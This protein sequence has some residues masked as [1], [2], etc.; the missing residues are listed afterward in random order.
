MIA[1]V[2]SGD[3]AAMAARAVQL[4]SAFPM[5]LDLRIARAGTARVNDQLNPPLTY[6]CIDL[7]QAVEGGNKAP[8]IEI[9]NPGTPQQHIDVIRPVIKNDRVIGYLQL[10]NNIN[11]IKVWLLE[12]TS[13]TYVE[14]TQH[15]DASKPGILLGKVGNEDLKTGD[16]ASY[17]V[18]G[19][20]WQAKVWSKPSVSIL[21]IG[22]DV[23]FVF[24]VAVLL[25]GGVLYYL[26]KIVS[27]A[28]RTDVNSL[29][30]LTIETLRGTKQHQ[31][32]LQM[33]EFADAVPRIEE[34]RTTAPVERERDGDPN[35]I[36]YSAISQFNP[37]DSLINNA[38]NIAVEEIDAP[39]S[40][41]KIKLPVGKPQPKANFDANPSGLSP[42]PSSFIAKDIKPS[43]TD[44]MPMAAAAASNAVP[45]AEIFK[46]YDIRGIVGASLTISYAHQIGRALGSEAQTR[47][48]KRIA[49]GR[50]GRLSGP[51]LGGALVQGL[52]D[53]GV[54]VIDVGMVPTPVLYYAAYELTEGS[55]VMLTGSHNPPQY[56]G[57]KMVLAGDT[58]SG[59]AITALR[60]RIVQQ[61]FSSGQGAYST[62]AIVK[63]YIERISGDV[64]LKRP[65]TVVI[66][67]GNGVAGAVAPL[68]FKSLGCQVTEL[69]CEVD[70]N[71]PNHHPDP[72]K[73]ENLR[74]VMAMVKSK[75]ADL[76]LAFDG[77]G[78]RV[79]V[80]DSSGKIIYPDRVLMML[81]GDVLSRNH[82]AQI[83]FDIK[84]SNNLTQVIW[85]KGG[86]PLMWKTGHSLIKS[87]MK[88]TG[89]LLAGEMSGHI[90]FKE[91]WY[92]F[93]DGLYS[94][95]RLLEI[96]A[97][98]LRKSAVMFAAFP[99]AVST[100]ELN[101]PMREGEPH[102]FIDDFMTQADFGEANITA[103]D[104]V[105][106]DFAD[107]WGLV[108]ASNTTPVLVLRFEGKTDQAMKRIQGL[109]KQQMLALKPDL[110]LPF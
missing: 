42:T 82:G 84:C 57:F 69:Y 24:I 86:E 74:D 2:E 85:E 36:S 75:H 89:A 108:R 9:H 44:I 90:F 54:D 100:P 88:Q 65:L 78:D 80:I 76:G 34:L 25:L 47:G 105:R 67:C 15:N 71:F 21:P 16:A 70:G 64:K 33:E 39:P 59:E 104:G 50:D 1:L 62:Q 29:L 94:G 26:R 46:A 61:N 8:P 93:D 22:L 18:G 101:V 31:F 37:A 81:A 110:K 5:A 92:G 103:I 66:D 13:D 6:A 55:G 58:L 28:I 27:A 87:K 52:R 48:V 43:P 20:R 68:L 106:A 77:D 102:R 72:S 3:E 51:E 60:E 83:I 107:G 10:V 30:L 63:Q 14:L 109:F 45:P 40:Q 97:N 98:D 32:H 53:A 23:L 11:A 4:K 19:T 38:N 7:I 79:G 56:N 49:F 73:P 96:L 35:A 91:R 41:P 17:T 95:A 12:N 99:D